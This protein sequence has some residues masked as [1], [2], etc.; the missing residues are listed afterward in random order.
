MPE[1]RKCT[2]KEIKNKWTETG[3]DVCEQTVRNQLKEMAF[4]SR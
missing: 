4:P 3:V 1:K 2:T